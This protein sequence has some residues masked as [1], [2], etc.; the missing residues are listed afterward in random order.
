MC[1]A[2]AHS[3]T[4][5]LLQLTGARLTLRRDPAR[6]EAALAEAEC[7]GRQSLADIRRSVGLLK[8]RG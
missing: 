4:V 5:T 3:L 6:A 1:V 7:I 8:K 2:V